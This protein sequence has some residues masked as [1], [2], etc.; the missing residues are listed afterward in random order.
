MLRLRFFELDKILT[1]WRKAINHPALRMRD[2]GMRRVRRNVGRHARREQHRFPIDRKFELPFQYM[3]PLF[4]EMAMLRQ[5]RPGVDR[6]MPERLL[7]G[8][9][10]C[11]IYPVP[12]FDY[13]IGFEIDERH[14]V[15]LAR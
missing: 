2:G 11:T 5:Y 14:Y 12:Y 15:V 4:M 13:F 1:R 7:L 9:A 3:A 6:E 8:M 10:Q